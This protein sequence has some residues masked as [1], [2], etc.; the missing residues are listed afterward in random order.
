MYVRLETIILV[1]ITECSMYRAY[2][3]KYSIIKNMMI[4]TNKK[5]LSQSKL[6]LFM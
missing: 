2:I 5:E 3:V 4:K 6:K 1:K